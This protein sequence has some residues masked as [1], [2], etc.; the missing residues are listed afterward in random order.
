VCIKGGKRKIFIFICNVV[1]FYHVIL[2]S[3]WIFA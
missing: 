1:H 3:K 2:T